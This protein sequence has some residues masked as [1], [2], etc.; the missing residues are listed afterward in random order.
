V[1]KIKLVISPPQVISRLAD[2]GVEPRSAAGVGHA[3]L[4][5]RNDSV[6][7]DP[8]TAP[9]LLAYIYGVRAMRDAF[10]APRYAVHSRQ[11]IESVF[12]I[13]AGRKIMFQTVDLACNEHHTPQPISEI[14]PAKESVIEY[15]TGYLFEEMQRAEDARQ[16]EMSAYDRAEAWYICTSFQND[17]VTC[18]LSR[19]IGVHEKKFAGFHE[20]IFILQG[21]GGSLPSIDLKDDSPPLDIKPVIRKR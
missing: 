4:A 18:E 13:T 9:G 5:A 10:T 1:I 17:H 14:G 20:R 8:K 6:P 19:P 15:S 7:T 11:N 12:D 2:F 3:A 21:G 16:R